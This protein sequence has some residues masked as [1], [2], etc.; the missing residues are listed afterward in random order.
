MLPNV[1]ADDGDMREERILV[2]RGDNLKLA[3]GRVKALMIQ[4]QSRHCGLCIGTHEPTPARALDTGSGRVEFLRELPV[5]SPA[6]NDGVLKGTVPKLTAVALTL[7]RGRSK[8]FPEER[9]VDVA[10][11]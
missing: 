3:S 11:A 8:V 9:M 4:N 2:G 10:C 6:L 1:N 7:S 5:R